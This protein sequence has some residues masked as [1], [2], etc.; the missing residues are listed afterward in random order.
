MICALYTPDVAFQDTDKLWPV[1]LDE[2]PANK[3]GDK[4]C[5]LCDD[6]R[7]ARSGKNMHKM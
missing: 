2:I 1:V 5:T 7:F 6:I 3:W 4:V